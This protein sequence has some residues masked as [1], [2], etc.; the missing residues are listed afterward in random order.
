MYGW[1][2]TERVS[3]TLASTSVSVVVDV[4]VGVD[5]AVCLG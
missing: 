2:D 4:G 3:D 1:L 5:V